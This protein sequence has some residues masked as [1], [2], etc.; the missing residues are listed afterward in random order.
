[1]S[2]YNNR[3]TTKQPNLINTAVVTKR[4]VPI[5]VLTCNYKKK[6]LLNALSISTTKHI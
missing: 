5:T 6:N 1:M 4:S 3:T 2:I